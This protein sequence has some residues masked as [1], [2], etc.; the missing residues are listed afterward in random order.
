MLNSTGANA[1]Q[2]S[3]VGPPIDAPLSKE[4]G[5]YLSTGNLSE[6][7]DCH[8]QGGAQRSV[9]IAHTSNQLA[10][11]DPAWQDSEG[12]T[13][14]CLAAQVGNLVEAQQLVLRGADVHHIN[15]DGDNA[16]TL[17]AAG[18]H[19]TF[20]KWLDSHCPQPVN[21]ENYYGDT[22]L[23]L[24]ARHG[25]QPL[26][27]WLVSRDASA[28]HLNDQLKDALAEA[29]ANGHLE[30]A[31][32]LSFQDTD[33]R[34]VY[35]DGNNLF[36]YAVRAGHQVMAQWL[37]NSGVDSQQINESGDNALTLAARHGHH[38]LLAWL[39]GK[40]PAGIHQISRN[41]D[42]L[43]LI[44]ARQGHGQTVKLLVEHGADIG[45]VNYA[46]SNVL[47]LAA[48]CSESLSLWLC[49]VGTDIH[50]IELSGNN[51]FTL[52]AQSGFFQLMQTLER[53]GIN[54]HQ[55]NHNND[56]AFTLVARQGSLPWCQWLAGKGINIHQVNHQHHNAVTLA[57]LAGSQL[58]I[59]W[60]C[61]EDMDWQQIPKT[62]VHAKTEPKNIDRNDTFN[63]AI[64]AASAGHV[65]EAEWLMQRGLNIHQ[66]DC[67]NR[68]AVIQA[69]AL[70]Q[71][72][73]VKWFTAQ[74]VLPD[75]FP[76]RLLN[77]FKNKQHNAM[78]LAAC[79]GHLHIL[80]WLH[81]NGGSLDDQDDERIL[82]IMAARR[83]DL[84]M[85]QWLC[86]QGAD[87]G[88]LN[89]FG[90]S[91]LSVAVSCGHLRLSQWLV[92]RGAED[93][94][95]AEGDDALMLAAKGGHN[96]IFRWL[97]RSESL[98]D[99]QANKLL[100]QALRSG[101]RSLAVWLCLNVCNS[102]FG[103]D[104]NGN[105]ALMLA[106]KNGFLWL[107]QWLGEQTQDIDQTDLRGY[108]ALMLAAANGHL[109]VVQWLY[110]EKKAN[111][112]QKSVD[113]ADALQLAVFSGQT[114][115]V[116]WL[117]G[118]GMVLNRDYLF[119][120]RDLSWTSDRN[121]VGLLQ[122]LLRQQLPL[123]LLATATC[124][125]VRE[126]NVPA[127]ACCLSAGV[128][129]G[130]KWK[131]IPFREE[132]FIEAATGGS[133]AAL[134]YLYHH[135]GDN[136][137]DDGVKESFLDSAAQFGN[138]HI[139]Q[140]FWVRYGLTTDEQQ[141]CLIAASD[142]DQLH[143]IKWLHSQR[144]NIGVQTVCWDSSLLT[145]LKSGKT[146]LVE[147]LCEQGEDL[148]QFEVNGRSALSIAIEQ[149]SPQLAIQLFH[150][151][152]RLITRDIIDIPCRGRSDELLL[153]MIFEMTSQIRRAHLFYSSSLIQKLRLLNL[154]QL[155]SHE[156]TPSEEEADTSFDRFKLRLLGFLQLNGHNVTPSEEEADASFAR[157]NQY[158]D[159][160]LEHKCLAA[161]VNLIAQQ[162]DTLKEGLKVVD[163]LPLFHVCK[164]NLRE[165]LI[166]KLE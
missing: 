144:A 2:S 99:R 92:G 136:W 62:L 111:L 157:L 138:L 153:G 11:A 134:E 115:T 26:A 156:V 41:G 65:D 8:F 106:A 160:T 50:Q 80:Q 35:P 166:I 148:H 101:H 71:L 63:A 154:L 51:A 87:I 60:L 54:I 68:N 52:A 32:W 161:L 89:R 159:K 61:N 14:L 75:C 23:T 19:L 90:D 86:Q 109:P 141:T 25:H 40:N 7:D 98:A 66:R 3:R 108:T 17:A 125:A 10:T 47:T 21:H 22:A 82:L 24:A 69:V 6:N 97:I 18:G 43:L 38:Q 110:R 55:V 151:G 126:G 119:K 100:L 36:L 44:A 83:G 49:N 12:N 120:M 139:I 158:S 39:L 33:L 147:W 94:P 1:P 70:G 104:I 9:T 107:T 145:A 67:H 64:L 30:L 91:A 123:R 150:R 77:C 118:L 15:L 132:C 112:H 84:P 102:I 78:S 74:G 124:D 165:L 72:D 155:N 48:A 93:I 29:V 131:S 58:L 113:R 129:C 27:Q 46:G 152:C 103:V 31:I 81:Q 163:S 105:N 130:R 128:G 116:N 34:R 20:I 16:L 85:T 13:P 42:S 162:V 146:H 127:L 133:V 57:A 140:W 114:E 96:A 37:E 4:T 73:A 53:L 142:N 143:V 88:R 59:E 45:L 76:R 137:G 28:V 56:N 164:F 79:L 117:I 135:S 149:G 122:C 95:N 5:T 121:N